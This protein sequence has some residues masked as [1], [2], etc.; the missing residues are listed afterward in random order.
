[1]SSSNS[2]FDFQH[3]KPLVAKPND[4]SRTIYNSRMVESD[5]KNHF[6]HSLCT[7]LDKK[8]QRFGLEEEK[9]A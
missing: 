3:F 6:S 9:P 2:F 5:Q 7:I 4:L 1:L 8:N